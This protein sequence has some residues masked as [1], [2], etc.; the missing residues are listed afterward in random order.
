MPVASAALLACARAALSKRT[1]AGVQ[2]PSSRLSSQ[3]DGLVQIGVIHGDDL[4]ILLE[5][6]VE[7][8]LTKDTPSEFIYQ[9]EHRQVDSKTKRRAA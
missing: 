1:T 6:V 3:E 9:E 2:R 7:S 8:P 4:D 5:E